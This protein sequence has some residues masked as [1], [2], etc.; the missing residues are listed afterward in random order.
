MAV[1]FSVIEKWRLDR[2]F[3]ISMAVLYPVIERWR[4][5]RFFYSSIAVGYP[6]IERRVDRFSRYVWL[7][8]FQ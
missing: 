1:G 8:D 5:D 3:Y 7:L 6:V 4:V 2:F